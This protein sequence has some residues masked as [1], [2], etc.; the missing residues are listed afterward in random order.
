MAK[1]SSPRPSVWPA[2]PTVPRRLRG[3]AAWVSAKALDRY[4]RK[5]NYAL[6][7]LDGVAG[8]DAVPGVACAILPRFAAGGP[9]LA[10][11]LSDREVLEA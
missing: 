10:D 4:K 2:S 3:I 8:L 9:S 1:A 7:A 5:V 11:L 6:T